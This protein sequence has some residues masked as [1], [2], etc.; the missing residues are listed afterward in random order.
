MSSYPTDITSTSCSPADF[1][2][3]GCYPVDITTVSGYPT[4]II[5]QTNRT[6]FRQKKTFDN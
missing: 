5:F 3:V 4:D 1:I 2:T 6:F